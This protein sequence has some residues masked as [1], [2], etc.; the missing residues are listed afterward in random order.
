[1]P[2]YTRRALLGAFLLLFLVNGYAGQRIAVLDFELNDIT[3]LPNTA[4]EQTR[5]AS[6]RPLLEQAIR[7]EGDFE[8]VQVSP[9][10]QAE[11]NA[12]FGYLFRF[13]ELA[14]KLG[15][16]VGADWVIV[17]QHSKPSFLFSYLQAQLVPVNG[18]APIA[19]LNIE[20][21]GNHV[22]VTQHGVA[23]LAGKVGRLIAER[24]ALPETR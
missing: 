21:K 3:S 17:G 10:A 16:Q 23:M 8:I 20:L 9:A 24:S 2:C 1:M 19:R 6:I 11:A 7:Q 5:T 12:G 13:P 18:G 15:K 22:S 14:A 4:P